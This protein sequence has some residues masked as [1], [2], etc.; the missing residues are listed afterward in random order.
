[1]GGRASV[2][3]L[4]RIPSPAKIANF[5]NGILLALDEKREY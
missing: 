3:I 5:E 1:M 4:K 2:E